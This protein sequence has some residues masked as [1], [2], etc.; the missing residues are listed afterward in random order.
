MPASNNFHHAGWQPSSTRHAL[1]ERANLVRKIRAFFEARDVLEVDTPLLS[2]HATV[3]RHIESFQV[4]TRWLQTSP[5]FAMKRLL[6][7]GAG[8]IWQLCKVFRAE[9]AG[10]FHNP[11]FSLLEWY[12][13]GLDH[14]ALMDEVEAL[15]RAVGACEAMP[16][17]R[18]SY[19]EA[20]LRHAAV[21]AFVASPTELQECF[22]RLGGTAAMQLTAEEKSD[23]D[24]WLDLLMSH[25]VAPKLGLDSPCFLYDFPVSQAALARIDGAVAARF[26]VIWKGVELANGFHELTDATEQR[27][28]FER[29]QRWR[30][31]NGRSVPPY[32]ALLIDALEHGLPDCAGVAV[33]VDRLLM[34]LLG[35]EKI[36]EVL[37]FDWQRA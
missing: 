30:V 21:D 32:D 26:E 6:A 1:R 2:Q 8:S 19:R 11:E 15:L 28:R 36:A 25:C 10:R 23:M 33:G 18:L 31:E 7:A 16:C 5:E 12:R 35:A 37:A 13:T 17:E 20:F 29:D 27:T 22:A 14:H 24:F 34:L 3:D 4:G 9:E